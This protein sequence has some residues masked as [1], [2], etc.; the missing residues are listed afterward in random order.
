MTAHGIVNT[1]SATDTTWPGGVFKALVALIAVCA[2]SFAFRPGPSVLDRLVVDDA[3]YCFTV[4]RNIARGAGVTIDGSTLTNGFQPLFVF[5]TVPLFALAGRHSFLAIRL[6]LVLECAFFLGTAF[7]LG[8]IVRDFIARDGQPA[9]RLI[10]W[11]TALLYVSARLVF[12]QHL[13][14]LE[15]GCLMFLY[16]ATWRYYQASLRDTHRHYL[17]LDSCLGFSSWR[18]SMRSF[19]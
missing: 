12:L 17:A 1:P 11:L 8:Q 18:E 14:G 6:V 2:L 5:L 7:L 9:R 4:S 15:T 13:N 3:Y 10:P 16:A 19:L